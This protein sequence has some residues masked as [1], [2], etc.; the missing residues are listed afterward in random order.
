MKYTTIRIEGAILSADILTKIDQGELSGQ[1]AKDFGFETNVKVKDEIAR[2]WADAQDMWRV[3][4]RR[5]ERV[6]EYEYGT[7][8]TRK[9]WIIPLLEMLGYDAVLSTKAET[10]NDKSYAISHRAKNLDGFPV[11]VMGFRDNLDKK[12]TDSGPRMSPHGLVQEYIN[13]KEHLYA[14]VSN[15]TNLRLLRD[16]SRLIKLSFIEFDL[17]SMMNDEHF[18]DFALMYRLLHAT[19]MPKSME[20]AGESLIEQY[21]QDALDSGS[22]IR[23]GLSRAVEFSIRH[24][25]NG[26]LNH[27]AN[28]NLREAVSEERITAANLYDYLLKLIYRL[29]FLMVIEERDLV[30]PKNS[31]KK[32]RDIYY[33]YYSVQ[34][35]R[36]LSEKPHLADPRFCDQWLA[37]KNCFQLF[38][39][40]IKGAK[41]GLKPLAGDLFG[42]SAIA[43]LNDCTLDNEVLLTSL[44]KLCL[45]TNPVSGQKMRVNYGSLNVEEFGSV[46]EGLLE[47]D[48]M[49]HDTGPYLFDFK[50]GSGRSISGSHYTP[51]ELV[52]PLIKHSLDYIIADRLKEKDPIKALLS[53]K[54]CDVSCGSGH[55]LLNAARRIGAEVA[56]LRT[57]ED[58]PSPEPFR[59]G[60]RDAIAN[61]IYGV[62]KNP[63]AVELC[64][65][66]L[67]LEA[68]N[69]GKPLSF[70]DHHIKC[71]DAIVG[72][73]RREEME[74]GVP[75]EAFATMPGDHKAVAAELRKR[76]KK[77]RLEK[78]QTRLENI[79]PE[80]QKQLD[81][82]L[83]GWREVAKLPERS[84]VEIEA[85]KQH[86]QEFSQSQEAWLLNQVAAIPIAQF[87]LPKT[88]ENH[89]KAVT[90]LEYRRYLSGQHRPQGPATATAWALAHENRF[91]H[92]FLEF[93]EIIE[94][95]GFDCILGNP[96]Y[97]GGTHLSGSYGYPFCHYVKWEYAP[98]GLSDL[99]AYF[100][101]RIYNLLRPNGF[102]A[103]ITTNSI[104]DGDI[105]KDGLEQVL[106]EG[107]TINMAVR[108]IK[109][110]GQANLVVSL[111][112]IRRGDWHG[113]KE[114]DKKD[115]PY[116]SA[117]FEE[118]ADIGN[119]Y[120]LV[121]NGKGIYKGS[122]FMG[123]GFLLEK[124]E[125]NKLINHSPSLNDVIFPVINGHEINNT[126][127]QEPSRCIINF[128]DWPIN[129]AK[130]YDEAFLTVERLVRPER[131]KQKDKGA[132]EK[133]WQFLRPRIELYS[134]LKSLP[135]CFVVARTTKHLSFSAMPTNLVFTEALFVMPSADWCIFAVV[136]STLH[137]VWSRKYSGA[138]KQDL[139]Y[140][141]SKCFDTFPF[142]DDLW[143]Q[144]NRK[145]TE[146]G[147]Q[148]HEYR[149]ELMLQL[150]L[151]LTNIYNLFHER[152]L[153]PEKVAKVSKKSPE[154]AAAG[155]QAILELRLLHRQLDNTVRDAYGWT[156]LD[157]AHD[158]YEIETLP[159]KDRLRYTISPE[160]RKELLKRLLQLN[161]EI[162]AKEEAAGLLDKGKTKKPAA[163][164]KTKNSAQ[165]SLF[166]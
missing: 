56:K 63:L 121:G 132:K 127:T 15:G 38:E 66:A 48:P 75:D 124:D 101:R 54:V 21:H 72:F 114:L 144:P 107:G 96:P 39:S 160:A 13:L 104:K 14:I 122:D 140:S 64:K 165:K 97:L 69:P 125:A 25:A 112:G 99:V 117:F 7:T 67:W 156:D 146:A 147:E 116:I 77:E 159:E 78:D 79:S 151:G 84:P 110:P 1:A 45:F 43:I 137:E 71:G 65:V 50:A 126:P 166:G 35:L 6:A 109:W 123:E 23:D 60:V 52:Q 27:P 33:S 40:E 8:E 87:Y 134:K 58:Q 20:Q 164:D 31:D 155:Y 32:L 119:P 89:T 90:D 162:H 120:T 49:I 10:V 129:R 42:Y 161:H 59:Q 135:C 157:L 141:P 18:A 95:G 76:N 105:R 29:L 83:A 30:Y 86:Y 16:S 47:K 12:R 81:A 133:W 57:G 92:W 150:W 130:Q 138:L 152:D 80:I 36:L 26:F 73:A 106:V 34:S 98:T 143:T 9:F 70:L 61:C 55:I 62:D 3:Y 37:L 11:H 82:I 46:Y 91:F 128:F 93:P 2:A 148:Y 158:F 139:R 131:E 113:K 142:P 115:V 118:Y 136:Q 19:R 108:G 53:I 111:V 17:A 22:R 100:V 163:K 153:T 85:K 74:R 5:M 145:L 28:H 149:R 94:N 4:R 103:F 51:D 102:T 41:L 68:H 24:L 88:E 154:E 44:H